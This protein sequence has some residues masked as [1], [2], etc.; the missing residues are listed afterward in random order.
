MIYTVV[1]VLCVAFVL[2]FVVDI[3]TSACF[4]VGAFLSALCGW[5]GMSTAVRS[6]VRTTAAAMKSLDSALSNRYPRRKQS[7]N[8]PEIAFRAGSVMG[9]VVVSLGLLGLSI[10][11]LLITA[12]A[13]GDSLIAIQVPPPFSQSYSPLPPRA[14]QASALAPP[15]S[16]F[17]LAWGGAS[18]QRRLM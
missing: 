3:G 14:Q 10:C 12:I 2:G 4:V 11:I 17:S 8:N 9:L 18:L 7:L 5:I 13:H 15:A 1:F 16:P 6:N